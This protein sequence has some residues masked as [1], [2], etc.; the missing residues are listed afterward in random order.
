MKQRRV[1]QTGL[2]CRSG[3]I[4]QQ[5]ELISNSS[6]RLVGSIVSLKTT[7]GW[8]FWHFR[9]VINTF[10]GQSKTNKWEKLH[11]R[12]FFF[13]Q[14]VMVSNYKYTIR[15]SRVHV[16]RRQDNVD[17]NYTINPKCFYIPG[18]RKIH[19]TLVGQD[20]KPETFLSFWIVKKKRGLS[21]DVM[22]NVTLK[23]FISKW[24]THFVRKEKILFSVGVKIDNKLRQSEFLV[25]RT[26]NK[27]NLCWL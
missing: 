6:C 22:I 8:I 9:V 3:V 7:L 21:G 19:L 1:G 20:F 16:E 25:F 18:R 26:S 27:I 14:F 12:F 5:N 15:S 23:A 10:C 11:C 4:S 17:Q 13:L 2:V 24:H